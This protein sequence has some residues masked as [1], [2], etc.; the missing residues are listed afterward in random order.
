MQIKSS[1]FMECVRKTVIF[2][3]KG[4][5]TRVYIMEPNITFYFITFVRNNSFIEAFSCN[6]IYRLNVAR[7]QD[8]I[9]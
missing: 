7:L 3:K 5:T 9:S 6:T 1:L 2:I 4:V 8:G